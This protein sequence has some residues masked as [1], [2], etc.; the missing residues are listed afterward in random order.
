[1]FEGISNL[2]IFED[3]GNEYIYTAWGFETGYSQLNETF[4]NTLLIDNSDLLGSF[5]TTS[6]T[7]WD[8]GDIYMF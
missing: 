5:N 7:K 1:M 6:K 2:L 8:Y 3:S 4:N